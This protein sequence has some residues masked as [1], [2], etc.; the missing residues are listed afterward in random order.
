MSKLWRSIVF[1]HYRKLDI[2][3]E[4]LF[5]STPSPRG[6]SIAELKLEPNEDP[7]AQELRTPSPRGMSIAELKLE[8]N[9]DPTAQELRTANPLPV[10]KPNNIID[11]TLGASVMKK[12]NASFFGASKWISWHL[13]KVMLKSDRLASGLLNMAPTVY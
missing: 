11:T 6:M 9:E 8:P 5:Q 7:T 1:K 13:R 10:S 3:D 4:Q 2:P 12:A